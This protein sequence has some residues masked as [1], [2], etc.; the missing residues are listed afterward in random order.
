MQSA[1]KAMR[2]PD[3]DLSARLIKIGEITG[4]SFLYILINNSSLLQLLS[5]SQYSSWCLTSCTGHMDFTNIINN[6]MRKKLNG[7][8]VPPF[9][10]QPGGTVPPF[11]MHPGGTVPRVKMHPGG[12]VPPF[13]MHPGGTVPPFKM[14]P[15]GTLNLYELFS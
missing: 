11:K 7:G 3:S 2:Q 10:I 15:G 6:K 9:K 14:H 12:T 13:K 5:L 8:T 1:F 4:D